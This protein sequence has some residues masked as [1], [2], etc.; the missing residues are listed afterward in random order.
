MANGMRPIGLDTEAAFSF[1]S[2]V[3]YPEDFSNPSE[4]GR[5]P[6]D[7]V[8]GSI[9][10]PDGTIGIVNG[11]IGDTDA[12]GHYLGIHNSWNKW[13]M[14]KDTLYCWSGWVHAGLEDHIQLSIVGKNGG[15][16]ST[17][18]NLV[19]GSVFWNPGNN[20]T[21]VEDH[22]DGWWR[23]S[24]V[25]DSLSGAQ[26]G[27][28]YFYAYDV[29]T[30]TTTTGDGVNPM[31]YVWGV[32]LTESSVPYPYLPLYSGSG[33]ILSVTDGTY[34]AWGFIGEQDAVEALGAEMIT[35]GDC[36]SDS[37][38]Q[39]GA[40]NWAY[41]AVNDEYDQ[42][43]LQGATDYLYQIAGPPTDGR[44]YKALLTVR[45]YS[46]GNVYT[47]TRNSYGTSRSADGSYIDY[48]PAK[49]TAAA[50]YV[51]CNSLFAGSV[52][53]ISLKQVTAVGLDGVHMY[54][55]AGLST[56][57][58]NGD[59][60]DIDWNVL[61]GYRIYAVSDG[62]GLDARL[63]K[64]GSPILDGTFSKATDYEFDSDIQEQMTSKGY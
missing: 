50:H 14:L 1:G 37:F 43:G 2:W 22:G 3:P 59:T 36:S 15:W 7:T 13:T 42:D 23:L 33:L 16:Y 40:Q 48:I 29:D 31:F 60:A 28:V 6:G 51:M 12:A 39:A 19:D 20:L 41:D 57:S 63:Y 47:R 64:R 38:L 53:D 34:T 49:G 10:L 9:T 21:W 30:G 45:N 17:I 5:S 18:F 35:D 11:M 32:T 62:V 24:I 46:A 25:H 26:N 55:E 61:T 54:Q 56:Q 44:L 52:D 8:G 27:A 58:W 4:W